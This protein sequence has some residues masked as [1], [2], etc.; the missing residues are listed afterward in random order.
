MAINK[1]TIFSS[2]VY[3]LVIL[4]LSVPAICEAQTG[5]AGKCIIVSDVHFNPLYDVSLIDTLKKTTY[6]Q[7]EDIFKNSK[8]SCVVD[9]NLRGKDSNYGLLILAIQNMEKHFDKNNPAAFIVITGDFLSHSSYEPAQVK[10]DGSE[11]FFKQQ[12]IFFI[13]KLFKDHF[14]NTTIVPALGNNDTY[15]FDYDKQSD[16]FLTDFGTAWGLDAIPGFIASLKKNQG[17]YTIEA[18]G[19]PGL[20]FDVFNSALVSDGGHRSNSND[21][22][23][24]KTYAEGDTALNWLNAKLLKQRPNEKAWIL[25]HIPPGKDP[26]QVEGN[27]T[28]SYAGDI[29]LWDTV[30]TKRFV[31]MMAANSAKIKFNIAA[32]SHRNDFRVIC[33]SALKPVSCVRV[34]PSVS[35][36]YTNNPSFEIAEFDEHYTIKNETTWYLD[37]AD[38]A[39]G[40]TNSFNLLKQ[41]HSNPVNPVNVSNFIHGVYG[42][43]AYINFYNVGATSA[44][45]KTKGKTANLNEQN[46]ATYQEADTLVAG[47]NP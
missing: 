31:N 3:L 32:H 43:D 40:W 9:S 17:C 42:L 27:K 4:A 5:K 6:K 16:A 46:H 45:N 21:A 33:N 34:I 30:Y 8:F 13:A 38:V 11:Q 24:G 22:Y 14:K 26:Y 39:K 15:N 25:Y 41:L 36:C 47:K 7:W 23:K 1:R 29:F 44:I 35:S 10:S 12:T 19:F 28:S 18:K 20:K 37:L 2:I